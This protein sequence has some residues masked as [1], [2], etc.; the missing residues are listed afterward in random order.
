M[1]T[2]Q[3]TG[4]S[5]VLFFDT[6]NAYQRTAVLKGAIDLDVFTAIGEG[7]VT[8]DA[9]ARRCGAAPR[10]VR[11]LC[12]YLVT[13]GF[14]AKSGERYALTPDAAAFL[15]RRSPAY[16][17]GATEFLLSPTITASFA[18][19]AG[20]VRK[21][22]TVLPQGGTVA[23]EHEVW[24]RFARAMA[25]MMA[26]AAEALARL[27]MQ[28]GAGAAGPMR[29]LDVAAGHGVFGIAVARANPAARVTA[30]DWPAV[31]EVARENAAR[32]GVA[33]R[34]DTLP[35]DAFTA[36]L[37][38][39]YDVVLLPN[40]LHHF[41]AAAIERLLRRVR[42]ALAPGGRVV[43]LEFIPDDDRVSPPPAATFAMVM[44][45]S[46]P[47]GDAYTF[48]EY[49]AMFR[50]AGFARNDR[51]EVPGTPQRAIVSSRT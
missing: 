3:P 26:P 46:T 30:L 14:L 17:G 25:P 13:M 27:V 11:V 7:D 50:A 6:I 10:G 12:D 28:S 35:G 23:P 24:V 15:D 5:P 31:L 18:D 49:E 38:G 22:G 45:A 21:G 48:R 42:E 32:A 44:L 1:N 4:P 51:H 8:T 43:T 2:Q 40:F 34:F 9:I 37:R 39:P 47:A 20:A 16:M 19:V 41:D 36:D 29:V 33:D